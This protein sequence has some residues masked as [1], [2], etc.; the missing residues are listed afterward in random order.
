MPSI[1]TQIVKERGWI[2]Y[3]KV[4]RIEK[5]KSSRK[6]KRKKEKQKKE[7]DQRL[8]EHII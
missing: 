6:E 3:I 2:L 8:N 7:S 5:K 4:I 1:S